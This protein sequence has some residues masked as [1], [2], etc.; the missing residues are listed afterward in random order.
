MILSHRAS[1]LFLLPLSLAFGLAAAHP[2]PTAMADEANASAAEAEQSMYLEV[3]LNQVA[4]GKLLKFEQRDGQ[5]WAQAQDLQELGVR[6]PQS[7]AAT[8]MVALYSID[9]L[10]LQF[11]MQLQRVA[12]QVPITGL[13]KPM[14]SLQASPTRAVST[15]PAARLPS[16]ILNYDMYGQQGNGA[17]S[18]SAWTEQRLMGVGPGVWSNTMVSRA[19]S[20]QGERDLGS[21]RLDTQW[22]GNFPDSMVSLTVGDAVTGA[23]S[24]SRSTRM[25]GIKLARNFGLQPYRITTPLAMA[26]SEAVLPSTVDL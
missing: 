16:L 5:L 13:D 4:T 14:A 18:L 7:V 23:V 21:V 20:G 3:M 19:L 24:W 22:Q 1:R 12:L 9:G 17:K 11:D 26:Q 2:G 10:Q 25:G 6:L 15:D 8:A